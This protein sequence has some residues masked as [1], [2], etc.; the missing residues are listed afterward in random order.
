MDRETLIEHL[1]EAVRREESATQIY[2]KHLSAI[3]SRSGIPAEQIS[4]IQKSL[5]YLIDSNKEHKAYLLSLI[6]RIK[7]EGIDVY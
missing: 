1:K 4:S 6:E 3:I 5:K 7:G 2:L